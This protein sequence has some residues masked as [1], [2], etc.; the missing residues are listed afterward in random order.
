M[1]LRLKSHPIPPPCHLI[2]L[3]TPA[4]LPQDG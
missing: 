1:E 4:P 3:P 2:V